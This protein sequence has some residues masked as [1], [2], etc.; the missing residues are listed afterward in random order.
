MASVL[1]IIYVLV[2]VLVMVIQFFM[3]QIIISNQGISIRIRNVKSYHFFIVQNINSR[4]K[5]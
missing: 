3:V 1:V 2:I 5:Q 4:D